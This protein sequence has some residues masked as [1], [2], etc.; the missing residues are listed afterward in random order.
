[1]HVADGS[2]LVSLVRP[3]AQSGLTDWQMIATHHI[4]ASLVGV[5]LRVQHIANAVQRFVV[6]NGREL[7]EQGS[8]GWGATPDDRSSSGRPQHLVDATQLA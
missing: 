1:M 3:V 4:Q 7:D 5:T 8:L 2:E 6:W